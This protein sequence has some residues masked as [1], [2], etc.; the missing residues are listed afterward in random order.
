MTK[1]FYESLEKSM[2]DD[3][4]WQR[5]MI[6]KKPL[7]QLSGK[8]YQNRIREIDKFNEKSVEN[9]SSEWSN[10]ENSTLM[11]SFQGCVW[12]CLKLVGLLS[13]FVL[14]PNF[15]DFVDRIDNPFLNIIVTIL[16]LL[17]LILFLIYMFLLGAD[18]V[19]SEH[20]S[21]RPIRKR[22]AIKPEIKNQ[23]WNRDGGRCVRCGSNEKLEFDHI[24]PHS[25]G[26]ADT[27][28]N[29]QLLCQTCNR[30]K[31]ASI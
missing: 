2:L 28:R 5:Y 20:E 10:N 13:L 4:D 6:D 11:D 25:K 16:T 12:E 30:S 18:Y 26:G 27:Y 7:S 31:G 14:I 15:F 3:E 1:D 8:E 29:L 9:K 17:F 24:I 22:K 23:V 21:Y 19:P